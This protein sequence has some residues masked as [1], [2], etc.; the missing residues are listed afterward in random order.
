M[1]D[2]TAFW[3]VRLHRLVGGYHCFRRTYSLSLPWR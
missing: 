2:V 1:F 3:V